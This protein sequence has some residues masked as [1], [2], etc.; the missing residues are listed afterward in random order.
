MAVIYLDNG[1]SFKVCES[2]EEVLAP[3]RGQPRPATQDLTLDEGFVKNER[4]LTIRWGSLMAV[5][6]SPQGSE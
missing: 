6:D 4:V 2:R 3:R 1:L 5:V